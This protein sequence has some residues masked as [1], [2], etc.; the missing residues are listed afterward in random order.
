MTGLSFLVKFDLQKGKDHR[1]VHELCSILTCLNG[2]CYVTTADRWQDQP[3][4]DIVIACE[5]MTQQDHENLWKDTAAHFLKKNGRLQHEIYTLTE[6]WVR[7]CEVH[8]RFIPPIEDVDRYM[9]TCKRSEHP[10]KPKSGCNRNKRD[11]AK[12]VMNHVQ[13]R[14]EERSWLANAHVHNR[15]KPPPADEDATPLTSFRNLRVAIFAPDTAGNLRFRK[16]VEEYPLA[17]IQAVPSSGYWVEYQYMVGKQL[18]QFNPTMPALPLFPT[19]VTDQGGTWV[20]EH[21]AGIDVLVV[22]SPNDAV[23]FSFVD[24]LEEEVA[25]G[26]KKPFITVGWG[27]VNA[28]MAQRGYVD[29]CDHLWDSKLPYMKVCGEGVWDRGGRRAV[30]LWGT[31]GTD[32]NEIRRLL[33]RR[34]SPA[35]EIVD[36]PPAAPPPPPPAAPPPDAPPADAP[37][38]D[39]PPPPSS[40]SPPPPS[41]PP[42]PS[43]VSMSPPPPVSIDQPLVG[44]DFMLYG[45]DEWAQRLTAKIQ[46]MNG[47]A[48]RKADDGAYEI[49]SSFWPVCETEDDTATCEEVCAELFI[50]H[51]HALFLKARTIPMRNAVRFTLPDVDDYTMLR[52]TVRRNVPCIHFRDN[53]NLVIHKLKDADKVIQLKKPFTNRF[54]YPFSGKEPKRFSLDPKDIAQVQ[55]R[56]RGW[57]RF[58]ESLHTRGEDQPV[59]LFED[60]ENVLCDMGGSI[61]TVY[62]GSGTA[63]N[64]GPTVLLP[65]DPQHTLRNFIDRV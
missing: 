30:Q 25:R 16:G 12:F 48:H 22:M 27:W 41:A 35:I 24:W 23:H 2:V 61:Y 50:E 49:D 17:K 11:H 43:M 26:R 14:R 44:M 19:L 51:T 38:A 28:C 9:W 60:T 39:A 56:T 6:A 15:P 3:I 42:A 57:D 29:P 7:D 4:I 8:S 58:E 63:D 54:F 46:E 21:A 1:T 13:R 18:F 52:R 33:Y 65:Q 40:Q 59:T 32:P 10:F 36:S 64:P 47:R 62:P 5:N 53:Q 34:T 20:G 37:P 45:S 31:K 55:R